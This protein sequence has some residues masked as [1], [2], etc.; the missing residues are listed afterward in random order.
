MSSPTLIGAAIAIFVIAALLY[1]QS[2]SEGFVNPGVQA[3]RAQMEGAPEPADVPADLNQA[4]ISK[5]VSVIPPV[6][7]PKPDVIPGSTSATPKKAIATRHEL[8]ELDNKLMTWLDAASQREVMNPM[9]LSAEQREKRVLYQSRSSAVRQQLGTGLITDTSVDVADQIM[10]LRNENAGWQS[11]PGYVD[12]T[13]FQPKGSPTSIL[14]TEDYRTFRG[15]MLAALSS[16][17]AN[18]LSNPLD[19]VRQ[20]QLEQIDSELRVTDR[21]GKTPFIRNGVAEDFLKVMLDS[22][23]PLPSLITMDGLYPH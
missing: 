1:L 7:G 18:P 21:Q 9:A 17:Q 23:Q 19:L 14:T 20:K 3:M 15:I 11:F 22:A 4:P 8:A 6:T 12:T 2:M 13:A 16:L 5:P 10:T